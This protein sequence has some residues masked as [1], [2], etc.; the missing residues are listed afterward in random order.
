MKEKLKSRKLWI[1]ILGGVAAALF[2]PLI[3][4][5]TILVPTYVG[6]QAVV[7]AVGPLFKAIRNFRE[8]NPE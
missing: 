7:D 4:V 5:I 1:T 2:P 8:K 6:G 3:P